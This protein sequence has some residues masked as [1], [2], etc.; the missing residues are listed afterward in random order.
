MPIRN[1]WKSGDWLIIDEE[2]GVTRYASEVRKDFRGLYVTKTYADDEQ[3]QDF[4][5]AL[6]DPRPVPYS[7]QP[8]R[9]WD[10]CVMLPPSIGE[11]HV[12]TPKGPADHLFVYGIGEMIIGDTCPEFVVR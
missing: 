1:S 5:K 6:D 10:I 11:T 12:P 4:I 2:S 7:N 8:D 9:D 3:P